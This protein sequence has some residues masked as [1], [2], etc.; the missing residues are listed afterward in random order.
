LTAIAVLALVGSWEIID[1]PSGCSVAESEPPTGERMRRK[2]RISRTGTR[3]L[4]DRCA[5]SV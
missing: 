4:V 1:Q 5:R 2:K 3:I